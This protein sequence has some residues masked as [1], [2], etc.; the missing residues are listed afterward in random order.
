MGQLENTGEDVRE[1][2]KHGEFLHDFDQ[3]SVEGRGHNEESHQQAQQRRHAHNTGDDH[4]MDG[5]VNEEQD[6]GQG[7]DQSSQREVAGAG[8]HVVQAV[9]EV[10]QHEYHDGD[11]RGDELILRQG[12]NEHTNGNKGG[13][14]QEEGQIAA[15]GK[16]GIQG[17]FKVQ[18]SHQGLQQ[19]Q[20]NDDQENDF[21]RQE[22]AQHNARGFDGAGEEDLIGLGFH[23]LRHDS[24]GEDGENKHD[25]AHAGIQ[26]IVVIRVLVVH[27]INDIVKAD[28]QEHHSDEHITDG[29][30]EIA[31]QLF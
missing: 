14:Q 9:G 3:Q 19:G 5:P 23:L 18:D 22:L 28:D 26:H 29:V 10:H 24:H 7:H 25:Q 31:S 17:A 15:Q 1:A 30:A 2:F 8:E 13:S 12:G 6:N 27:G 21:R 20:G 11:Y 16:G 4:L